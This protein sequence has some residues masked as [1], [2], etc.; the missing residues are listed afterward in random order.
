M[1]PDPIRSPALPVPHGF[2]TRLGGVSAGPFASLNCSLSSADDRDAVLANR[3]RAAGAIGAGPDSL[4]GLTQ[5]HGPAVVHATTA[6]SAGQGP[7]ADAMVTDRPGIALGIITADC[8]PVLFC[9][10]E[11]G[12]VG[13][14]HAGWR[15]ALAGVLEATVAAMRGLGAQHIAAVVGPCIRQQSYE[16]G[17]DLR[18]A[19]LARDPADDRFFALGRREAH[20]QFDLPGYCAARLQA[21]RAAVA[22]LEIDTMADEARFFSHRRR[23][24]SGGGPIGHQVSAIRL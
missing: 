10:A 6:W 12:V 3:A 5:V 23:T 9:D 18:D 17:A 13:A 11:A 4:L 21:A 19:V 14:A 8:A 24:L 7:R 2:F 22:V 1:L 20:W 16:V 15:G